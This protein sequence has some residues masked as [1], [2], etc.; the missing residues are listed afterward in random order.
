M[1]RTIDLDDHDEAEDTNSA[2]IGALEIAWA[3]GQSAKVCVAGADLAL[4]VGLSRRKTYLRASGD[5]LRSFGV[6][7]SLLVD[8]D[9]IVVSNKKPLAVIIPVEEY[10]RMTG[11]TIPGS[12]DDECE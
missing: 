10:E 8:G 4:I 9:V 6:L 11:R 3:N 2:L 5:C 7:N 1:M 12:F